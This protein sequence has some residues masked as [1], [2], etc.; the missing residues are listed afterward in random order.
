MDDCNEIMIIG[1]GDV[2]YMS[3]FGDFEETV[4]NDRDMFHSRIIDD[5]SMITVYSTTADN[6]ASTLGTGTN[7]LG[8]DTGAHT[9]LYSDQV[10]GAFGMFGNS[11]YAGNITANI[12]VSNC[13]HKTCVE[14]TF[15]SNCDH[16]SCIEDELLLI[17]TLKRVLMMKLI[18]IMTLRRGLMMK[19]ILIVT[20]VWVM[21]NLSI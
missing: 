5:I 15:L 13:D 17:V 16:K 21:M 11:T 1:W 4:T 2:S 3:M 20:C 19:P 9:N 14:D 8:D 12:T 6:H 18:L 7:D 10:D